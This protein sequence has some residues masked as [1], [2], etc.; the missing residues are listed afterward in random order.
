MGETGVEPLCQIPFE[1]KAGLICA[2]VSINGHGPFIASIDTGTDTIVLDDSLAKKLVLKEIPNGNA[3]GVGKR[4][5]RQYKTS[6]LNVE[7]GNQTVNNVDANILQLPAGLPSQAIL[8]YSFLETKILQI[9]LPNHEIRIFKDFPYP[10][11]GG[12]S[13]ENIQIFAFDFVKKVPKIKD[14]TI[15]GKNVEVAL[16]TGGAYS[17]LFFSSDAAR[18][19]GLVDA[20]ENG[21][22]SQGKGY[23]GSETMKMAKVGSLGLGTFPKF[24]AEAILIENPK[25][26]NFFGPGV[27]AL[28]EGFMKNYIMTFDYKDHLVAFEKRP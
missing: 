21:I 16:D 28:G 18:Q 13:T 5:V 4:E 17:L 26:Q 2:P 8:G 11:A 15:N 6:G 22:T 14:F 7:V 20:L 12:A 19:V 25:L 9:D 3:L 27:C 1:L 10:K 23:A 24:S